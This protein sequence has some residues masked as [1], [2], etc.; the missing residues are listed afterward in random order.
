MTKNKPIG[1]RYSLYLFG[2]VKLRDYFEENWHYYNTTP[3]NIWIY[4]SHISMGISIP[5]F[6]YTYLNFSQYFF[7][8]FS[9]ENL[10][11]FR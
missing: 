6:I 3:F 8:L 1:Q 9:V 5:I 10:Y 11:I 2:T 4:P 7:V